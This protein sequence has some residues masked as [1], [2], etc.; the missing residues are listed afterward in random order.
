MITCVT[1]D[2]WRT[3]LWESGTALRDGRVALWV[4]LLRRKGVHTS[5]EDV[6]AAH[7]AAF[8]LASTSW[9]RGVQYTAEDAVR[10]MTARLGLPA[11]GDLADSLAESFSFAGLQTELHVAEGLE[12]CLVALTSRG[13]RLGIVCDVGLTPSPVLREHLA[14]RGLL[15]H[16]HSWSF[17]DE[18]GH[19]K[20]SEDIFRHALQGLECKAGSAAHVGDLRRTDVA[21]AQ[22]AGLLAVRYRGVYD[23]VDDSFPEADRVVSSY[24][25]LLPALGL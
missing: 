10:E 1:F 13:I 16:F 21:G 3:L 14:R 8:Q 6:V 9:R 25:E 24:D 5:A 12:E 2:Y 20:P 15:E 23:D 17:S 18:V 4:D 11:Q 19:Y 22:R 7:E